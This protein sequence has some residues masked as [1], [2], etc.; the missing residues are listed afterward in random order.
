MKAKITAIVITKNEEKNIEN[1]LESI[2]WCDEIIIVDDYSEDHTAEIAKS[3]GVL[4]YKRHLN[5]DFAGQRNFGLEKAKGDW[6]LFIDADERVSDLLREEVIK[7]LSNK[8]TKY[9]GFYLKRRDFIWGRELRHGETGNVK[10]LR[11]AKTGTGRW[12]RA[13]H[14]TWQVTGKTGELKNPLLHYPHQTLREFI[15]DID[16]MSTLHARENKKEGKRSGLFKII[17]FP[18]FKFF[19]SWVLKRGFLDGTPGFMAAMIM[20][21]HS[22]LAW[23]KLWLAQRK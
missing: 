20:S 13:I 5:D 10:L 19:D 18:K 21:L 6:V 7:L 15:A 3:F 2:R 16:W 9:N 14:E 22:F 8:V 23:S 1:C 12:R 17:F 11:L 4:V